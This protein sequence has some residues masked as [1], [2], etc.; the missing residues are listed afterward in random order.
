MKIINNQILLFA[1]I[2]VGLIGLVVSSGCRKKKDTIAIIHVK[3][4]ANQPV[5]GARVIL[6]GKSTI[7]QPVKVTLYDTTQTDSEGKAVFNYNDVYQLGQAGVAILNIK[8]TY[9]SLVGEGIIKVE[10]ET[11]SEETVF[12]Q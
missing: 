2:S 3:N 7:N 1:F 11:T 5:S 9:N 4:V 6:Y 10:E 12:L 8:A